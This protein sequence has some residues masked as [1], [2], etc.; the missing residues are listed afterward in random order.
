MKSIEKPVVDDLTDLDV[1]WG[2]EEPCGHKDH[3]SNKRWW[4]DDG[5]AAFWQV[6]ACPV[7]GT[8][9]KGY[10]CKQWMVWSMS[11][12]GRYRC[13]KCEVRY[14]SAENTVF[15]PLEGTNP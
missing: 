11:S 4:H 2:E 14:R 5:L 12:I 10:R 8:V 15:T 13:I 3:G 1:S 7:C 9:T 6:S